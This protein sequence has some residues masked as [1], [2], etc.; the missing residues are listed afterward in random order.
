MQAASLVESARM[1]LLAGDNR[2][3]SRRM[4]DTEYCRPDSRNRVHYSYLHNRRHNV[5][6][7]GGY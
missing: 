7:R 4:G 2:R 6:V 3:K 5:A 1:V